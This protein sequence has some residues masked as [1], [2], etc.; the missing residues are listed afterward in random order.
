MLRIAPQDEVQCM[1]LRDCDCSRNHHH[2][3]PPKAA[4][5]KIEGFGP[6]ATCEKR[7]GVREAVSIA[8]ARFAE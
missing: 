8:V 2:E 6:A 7:G 4:S 5:R 3:E 1:R